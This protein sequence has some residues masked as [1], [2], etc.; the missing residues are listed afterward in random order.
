MHTRFD[1]QLLH[2]QEETA[3]QELARRLQQ[4]TAVHS[5]GSYAPCAGL[6]AVNIVTTDFDSR[7]QCYVF[8]VAACA[9]LTSLAVSLSNN[10]I[11]LY[12]ARGSDGIAYVGELS[13][14]TDTIS[15]VSFAGVEAPHALY[16]SSAD[17]TVRGWDSRTGQQAERSA[18]FCCGVYLLCLST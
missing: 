14:H 8:D 4:P 13:G 6:N 9:D 2:Q 1:D 5:T 3:D 17:G 11:K 16:S 10:T 18:M 12:T 15:E 7:D